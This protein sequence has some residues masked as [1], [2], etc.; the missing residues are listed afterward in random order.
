MDRTL[1]AFGNKDG[2]DVAKKLSEH[3]RDINLTIWQ[4]SKVMKDI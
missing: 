4:A 1:D 3:D 2:S